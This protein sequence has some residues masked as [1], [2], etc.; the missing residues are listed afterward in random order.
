MAYELVTYMTNATTNVTHTLLSHPPP[1]QGARP[2]FPAPVVLIGSYLVVLIVLVVLGVCMGWQRHG[3][4]GGSGGGGTRRPKAQQPTPPSGLG[5]KDE[6]P[7]VAH[8]S[9][10]AAW[11]EQLR[12]TG[13][14]Q[15]P[16]GGQQHPVGTD[17]KRS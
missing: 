3:G 2:Y 9:D 8:A 6:P 11:E 13:G 4:N 12:G 15:V 5:R 17:E 16:D 1:Q 10:F 7:L 14:Q